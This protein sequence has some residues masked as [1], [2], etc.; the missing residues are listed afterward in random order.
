MI[1]MALVIAAAAG[2]FRLKH[3]VQ[4][5]E[6]ELISLDRTLIEQREAIRVLNAEWSYLNRPERLLTLS[7][8]YLNLVP[9]VSGQ[10][11]RIYELSEP[12]RESQRAER[13]VGVHR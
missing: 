5:L 13:N 4:Q 1:G 2:L 12:A 7:D 3:E 10:F 8:R 11:G 6:A 9:L